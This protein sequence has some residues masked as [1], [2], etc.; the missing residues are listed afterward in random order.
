MMKVP[1]SEVNLY[2]VHWSEK[3]NIVSPPAFY[4]SLFECTE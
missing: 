2:Y 3:H 1:K 4:G